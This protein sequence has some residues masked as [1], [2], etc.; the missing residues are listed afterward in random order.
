LT[1]GLIRKNTRREDGEVQLI[2][3]WVKRLDDVRKK[4]FSEN[5][6]KNSGSWAGRQFTK[7]WLQN[8]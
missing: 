2:N 3:R 4:Y 8:E 1:D 6:K 5:T 7:H